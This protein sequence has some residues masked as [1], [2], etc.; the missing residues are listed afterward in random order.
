MD[1]VDHWASRV[2]CETCDLKFHT[3]S[4]AR[5]HMEAQGH[6]KTYCSTCNR[7]FMNENNLKMVGLLPP[8]TS[9]EQSYF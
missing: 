8:T 7:D 5:Q 2:P 3:L 1:A 9:F 6:Y 4:D